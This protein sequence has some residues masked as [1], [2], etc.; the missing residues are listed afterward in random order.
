MF[1]FKSIRTK[2]FWIAIICIGTIGI[3]LPFLLGDNIGAKDVPILFTTYYVSIYFSGCL[4]SVVS[5]IKNIQNSTSEEL[6]KNFLNIIGLILLSIA[7]VVATVLLNKESYHKTALALSLVGTL[8]GLRL[9]WIN[10]TDEPTFGDV[11]RQ[12]SKE[13]HGNNW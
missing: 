1:N 5:K 6:I 13:N 8:I 4:D 3:W 9:W 10:N 2:Y 12:E 7:L 11:I